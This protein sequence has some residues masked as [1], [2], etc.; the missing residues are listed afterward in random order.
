MEV[1][2]K[3]KNLR[4]SPRKVRLVADLIRGLDCETAKAQLQFSLKKAALPLLKLLNSC[5]A[6]AKHNFKLDESNLYISKIMV[7]EGPTLYRIMPRAFGRA[8]YIRKR[9]SHV[10][11]VLEEKGEN[12]K[13]K[14][15]A[16]KLADGNRNRKEDKKEK[17]GKPTKE[18][19]K[20]EKKVKIKESNK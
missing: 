19:I 6:N 5:I 15:E 1:K 8:F 17:E 9:T 14:K 10:I 4:M 2:A 20:E 11:L 13:N 12:K 7:N 18:K 16:E 3:L